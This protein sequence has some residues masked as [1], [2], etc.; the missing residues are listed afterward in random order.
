MSGRV[1]NRGIIMGWKLT[2]RGCFRN[3]PSGDNAAN[4]VIAFSEF[5]CRKTAGLGVAKLA[6]DARADQHARAQN[7]FIGHFLM[8][9]SD[10]NDRII[11][12]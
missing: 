1:D 2:H 3:P 9:E 10:N 4:N 7:A 5:I 8:F 12:L 6:A 11:P